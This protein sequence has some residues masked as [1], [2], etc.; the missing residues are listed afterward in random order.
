VKGYVK[1]IGEDSFVVGLAKNAGLV[2][3]PYLQVKEIRKK[4]TTGSLIA[5]IGGASA[6]SVGLL[7]LSSFLLSKC[8][9]CIGQ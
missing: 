4:P 9:P 6:A 1:S 5:L 3:I 2:Q 8:S 7:Y